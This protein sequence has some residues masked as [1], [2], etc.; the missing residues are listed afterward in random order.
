MRYFYI[1]Q[2][3]FSQFQNREIKSIDDK[4][5]K[6]KMLMSKLLLWHQMKQ[7]I[8]Y[9]QDIQ[10]RYL[11]KLIFNKFLGKKGLIK[12]PF[13]DD[14]IIKIYYCSQDIVA[15]KKVKLQREVFQIDKETDQLFLIIAGQ[16]HIYKNSNEIL[17]Y[18]RYLYK[19][20]KSNWYGDRE[21]KNIF[22]IQ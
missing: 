17:N 13:G 10:R 9:L 19:I 20:R 2:Y 5:F 11:N 6:R 14:D 3:P 4:M 1:R 18:N 16:L 21:Q 8:N 12:S 22:R 7:P 15:S